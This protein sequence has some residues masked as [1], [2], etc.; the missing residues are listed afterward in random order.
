MTILGATHIKKQIK[1]K[2]N[3]GKNEIAV[4]SRGLGLFS[5][6][7]EFIDSVERTMECFTSEKNYRSIHLL[8]GLFSQLYLHTGHFTQ[9][10][11][12]YFQLKM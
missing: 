11:V 3:E 1:E 5:A 7:L 8:D 4:L 10:V 9:Q 12:L 6:P 2:E